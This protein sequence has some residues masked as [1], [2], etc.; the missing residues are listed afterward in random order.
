MTCS[1]AAAGSAPGWAKTSTPSLKAISVG[2][3]VICAAAARACSASVSTLPNTMSGCVCGRPSRRR[4]RTGGTG[5]TRTPRSRR[6]RCRSR[7]RCVRSSPHPGRWWSALNVR[8]IPVGVSCHDS[9]V[10]SQRSG[11]HSAWRIPQGV[12]RFRSYI[13]PWVFQTELPNVKDYPDERQHPRDQHRRARRRPPD[14]ATVVDVREPGEYVAGHVPG[15]VL[16]PMG[17][18]PCSGRRARPER[19]GLRHLRLGQPQRRH[20]RLPAR[21]RLRRLLRRRRHRGL[22]PLRPRRRHGHQPANRHG[23]ATP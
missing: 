22:G 4:A 2:I 8:A 23:P 18:L 11:R 17:Q 20:D 21:S 10:F 16:I 1:S 5:R 15:A 3:E 13:P 14:G 12:L 6:G 7:R 19:P 9:P